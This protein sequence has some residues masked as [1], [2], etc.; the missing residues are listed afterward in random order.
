MTELL[1]SETL[2][3]EAPGLDEDTRF[4]RRQLRE[5]AKMSPEEFRSLAVRAGVLTPEGDPTA[6]YETPSP[7][8]DALMGSAL[9]FPILEALCSPGVELFSRDPCWARGAARA[10][11]SDETNLVDLAW[12]WALRG[13]IL[14]GR[15][16]AGMGA[17]ARLPWALSPSSLLPSL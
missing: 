1:S 14:Q 11:T 13:W 9:D 3:P 4:R 17:G 7:Y 6:P 8:R 10:V 2:A 12:P 15:R 16:G 5:M